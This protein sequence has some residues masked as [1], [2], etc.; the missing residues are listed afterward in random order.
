MREKE[1]TME[2]STA[3]GIESKRIFN[4]ISDKSISHRTA[5]EHI[6]VLQE[7]VHFTGAA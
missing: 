3:P 1:C 2:M 7:F 5:V 4:L 6:F